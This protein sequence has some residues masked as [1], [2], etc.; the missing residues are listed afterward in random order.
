MAF[1]I[2]H[3]LKPTCIVEDSGAAGIREKACSNAHCKCHVAGLLSF[4]S[5]TD[6]LWSSEDDE[7]RANV[8]SE[9]S[10]RRQSL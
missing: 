7:E 10:S 6:H 4:A 5:F 3:V 2:L 8:L 9:T 1:V